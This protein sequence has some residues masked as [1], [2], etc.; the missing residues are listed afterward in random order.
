MLPPSWK[1]EIEKATKEATNTE[2]PDL[3]K[4]TIDIATVVL[5]IG[6]VIFTGLSWCVFR[7]QLRVAQS[8]D[9]TFKDTLVA[10]NR[11]WL[12]PTHVDFFKPIDDPDGPSFMGHYQ[13]VGRYPALD[14]KNSLGWVAIPLTKPVATPRELPESVLWPGIDQTIRVGCGNSV[15]DPDGETVFPSTTNENN[16]LSGPSTSAGDK[17]E[18]NAGRQLIVIT[19]CLTYRT[20]DEVKHTGFC[21]YASKARTGQWEILSCRVGNFAN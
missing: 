3:V 6:T 10:A 4:R 21:R 14:V 8:S 7:D 11:A 12:A 5:L 17:S 9:A 20:F 16:M 19:G 1:G 18:I 15:P 13:N 2:R